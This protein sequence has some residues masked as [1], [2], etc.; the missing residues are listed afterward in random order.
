MRLDTTDERLFQESEVVSIE[1]NREYRDLTLSLE[2]LWMNG[3]PK[4]DYGIRS[5][6]TLRNC[7]W[8]QFHQSREFAEKT[9]ERE[10]HSITITRWGEVASSLVPQDM[11]QHVANGYKCVS[12]ESEETWTNPWIIAVCEELDLLQ[13]PP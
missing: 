5:N 8:A 1:W 13:P 12:F 10:R 4:P 7:I 9:T 11:R 6:L 2:G 3:S